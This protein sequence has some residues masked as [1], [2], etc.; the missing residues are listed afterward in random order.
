MEDLKKKIQ[1]L[2]NKLANMH[3]IN[4]KT[5]IPNIPLPKP[6]NLKEG[7]VVDNFKHFK[8]SWNNY[9]IASGLIHRPEK[10]KIASLLAT[11]GEDI[12]KNHEN[13]NISTEEKQ[14]A[15]ELLEAIGCNIK[16]Q[17]NIRYERAT[18]NSVKQEQL[19]T[20]DE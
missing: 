18:F 12:F 17:T 6:I 2:E 14:T 15:D 4:I 5:S 11:I 19:E 20:Y 3:E 8:R 1:H 16:P 10:E 7:D 9:I 13:Y